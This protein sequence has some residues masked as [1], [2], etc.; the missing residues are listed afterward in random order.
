MRHKKK[1]KLQRKKDNPN[2]SLW[3]RKADAAW[4]AN[5]TLDGGVACALSGIPSAGPCAGPLECHH[6]VSRRILHLRH[7][8]KNGIV[9]CSYHHKWSP[10]CSPHGGPVGFFALLEVLRPNTMD[11]LKE[12]QCLSINPLMRE[13]YKDAYLRLTGKAE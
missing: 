8:R 3:K 13:S 2:S 4:R 10:T 11:Y 12:M 7:N 6:I 5:L 9:L 1:S